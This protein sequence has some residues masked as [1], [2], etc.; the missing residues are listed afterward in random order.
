MV[1]LSPY[2]NEENIFRIWLYRPTSRN[3]DSI[4]V[5]AQS[6]DD[7]IVANHILMRN[8]KIDQRQSFVHKLEWIYPLEDTI[9]WCCLL[10]QLKKSP[11]NSF[12]EFS[13]DQH[14]ISNSFGWRA[15]ARMLFLWF[16]NV[17]IDFPWRI[18]QRRTVVSCDPE[19][20]WWKDDFWNFDKY[21][22][23]G[24]LWVVC[25]CQ[26]RSNCVCVSS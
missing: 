14:E 6:V 11:W 8:Q 22:S 5:D 9:A 4:A 20:T 24:N 7:W 21:S 26:N 2:R 13:Q 18:S 19:I 23:V 17:V 12:N 10:H 25:V 15:M 16:V 3:H 1:P